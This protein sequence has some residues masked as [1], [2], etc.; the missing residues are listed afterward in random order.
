MHSTATLTTCLTTCSFWRSVAIQIFSAS[1]ASK[2]AVLRSRR[3]A[4]RVAIRDQIITHLEEANA[5]C[6]AGEPHPW[7]TFVVAGGSFAGV[8]TVGGINDLVRESIRFY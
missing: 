8:E 2:M 4:M 7:L 6:A 1:L 5:E 3:S